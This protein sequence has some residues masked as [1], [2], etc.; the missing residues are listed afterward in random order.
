M[1]FQCSL[2]MQNDIY[3]FFQN[4]IQRFFKKS[5]AHLDIIH[6]SLRAPVEKRNILHAAPPSQPRSCVD[7]FAFSH[8]EPLVSLGSQSQA[9][10]LRQNES[11]RETGCWERE[12]RQRLIFV[13][14]EPRCLHLD[15][16]VVC[17]MNPNLLGRRP[18]VQVQTRPFT[19]RPGGDESCSPRIPLLSSGVGRSTVPWEAGTCPVCSSGQMKMAESCPCP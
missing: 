14:L 2:V 7:S 5:S 4:P 10:P 19:A 17:F 3:Y 1:N 6:C 15:T 11:T 8:P 18:C 9:L 12:Y 16:R 13:T